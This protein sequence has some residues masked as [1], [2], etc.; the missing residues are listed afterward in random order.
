M[1]T[2]QVVTTPALT[3]LVILS[4]QHGCSSPGADPKVPPL[5]EPTLQYLYIGGPEQLQPG[6][7]GTFKLYSETTLPA[8]IPV[9]TDVKWSVEPAAGARIDP[10]SGELT[11]ED[12]IPHGNTFTIHAD[13]ENG[14]KVLTTSVLIY[15][16][17]Q[18]PLVGVWVEKMQ[19]T[20]DTY[21]SVPSDPEFGMSIRELIFDA[22]G[23]YS[24]TWRPFEQYL[25]Y[26]GTYDVWSQGG[27]MSLNITRGNYIPKDFDGEGSISFNEEG[28]LVMV[29]IWL[30]N[31]VG[32][33]VP[34]QC[35]YVFA[36]Q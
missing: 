4:L 2:L 3:V 29:D 24:V 18:N 30:G 31:P 26:L 22:D 17:E 23:T 1:K 8:E 27:S 11:I 14:R 21:A 7:S 25:D 16:R 28:N 33:N 35:G 12:S 6:E 36:R 10:N 9:E 32:K 13:V 34:V 15:T 19:I 20:C 5:N